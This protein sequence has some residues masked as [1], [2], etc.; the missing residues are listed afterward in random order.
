MPCVNPTL[1]SVRSLLTRTPKEI[2]GRAW[3]LKRLY[4]VFCTIHDA[5]L[6]SLSC[7]PFFSDAVRIVN[8]RPLTTLRDQP[9]DLAPISPSSFLR[10]ELAPNT[11][12][13]ECDDTGGLRRDYLYNSTLAH[14]F[15]LGWMQSYLLSLQGRNKW[16]ILQKNLTV[17]Q[18]VLVKD[19]ENVT[20]RNTYRLER[21]H[22]LHQHVLRGKE[23]IRRATVDVLAKNTVDDP[24][25]IEYVLRDL[26]K[27]APVWCVF[28]V[29]FYLRK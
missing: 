5:C 2:A 8:D 21:I 28:I 1:F 9:N 4:I 20:Y 18:L 16:R 19:A 23:I 22:S 12:M 6:F 17:G 7:K 15:W 13:G 24:G 3:Y 14:R 10:Q 11:P 29:L 27:I 26:S 25:K